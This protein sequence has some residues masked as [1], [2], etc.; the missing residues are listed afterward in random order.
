MNHLALLVASLVLGC[1]GGWADADGKAATNIAR[2][3]AFVLL[4]CADASTCNADR[5]RA[6]ATADFCAASSMLVRHGAASPDSGV[7]CQP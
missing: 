3:Q 6:L 2:G 4:E 5:V 7:S 1:G